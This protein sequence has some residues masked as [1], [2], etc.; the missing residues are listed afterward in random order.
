MNVTA[1][2]AGRDR[3]GSATKRARRGVLVALALGFAGVI[4]SMVAAWGEGVTIKVT[5]SGINVAL[6]ATR[7]FT[8]TVTGHAD[9]RHLVDGLWIRH[10]VGVVVWPLQ[11]AFDPAHIW[12]RPDPGH[13]RGRPDALGHRDHPAGSL[14]RRGRAGWS[15]SPTPKGPSPSARLC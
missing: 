9:T 4:L 10:R 14:S 11:R 5:P 3:A 6:G 7:Q 13:L 12:Y 15:R 1:L 2:G 8:A